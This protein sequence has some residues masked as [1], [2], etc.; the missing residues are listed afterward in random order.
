[1]SLKIKKVTSGCV[2]GGV[3]LS[4]TQCHYCAALKFNPARVQE[5]LKK[6]SKENGLEGF[7]RKVLQSLLRIISDFVQTV[8]GLCLYPELGVWDEAVDGEM[9][10]DEVGALGQKE[11]QDNIQKSLEIIKSNIRKIFGTVTEISEQ[12]I[13]EKI[14]NVLNK[15]VNVCSRMVR[16]NEKDIEVLLKNIFNFESKIKEILSR[17]VKRIKDERE[18]ELYKLTHNILLGTMGPEAVESDD[19]DIKEK[20]KAAGIGIIEVLKCSLNS[21]NVNKEDIL[22][23]IYGI[24]VELFSELGDSNDENREPYFKGIISD[25]LDK[26]QVE[27]KR[28]AGEEISRM[29]N[30]VAGSLDKNLALT[31]IDEL[32]EDEDEDEDERVQK[33]GEASA[34]FEATNNTYDSL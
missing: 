2:M 22:G 11:S 21:K 29:C 24:V 17:E 1:M 33:I 7:V 27:N 12:K 30:Y 16:G 14:D 26:E 13:Q 10:L 3:L 25:L 20:V 31:Q 23:N 5:I 34:L 6:Q 19:E 28:R 8:Y 18:G 15:F 32:A 4:I 9:L